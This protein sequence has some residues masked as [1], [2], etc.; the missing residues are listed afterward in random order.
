MASKHA[1]AADARFFGVNVIG[2]SVEGPESSPISM[3]RPGQPHCR[4]VIG[5]CRRTGAAVL[6][7]PRQPSFYD[8]RPASV[9]TRVAHHPTRPV[10]PARFT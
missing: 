8:D 10:Q 1:A 2:V 4:I 7:A 6:P 9:M 5:R 3:R